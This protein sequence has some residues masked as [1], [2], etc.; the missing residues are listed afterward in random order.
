MRRILHRRRVAASGHLLSEVAPLLAVM[1]HVTQ[2]LAYSDGVIEAVTRPDARVQRLRTVPSV[3]P[4]RPSSDFDS[5]GSRRS[6]PL[7]RSTCARC[8]VSS[9]DLIRQPVMYAVSRPRPS[10]AVDA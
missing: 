4:V 10:I 2:Q 3:C 8:R 9:S 6:H 1:Q 7:T 5:P